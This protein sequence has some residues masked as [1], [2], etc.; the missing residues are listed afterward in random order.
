MVERFCE[1]R[2]H[3][4]EMRGWHPVPF[5]SVPSPGTMQAMLGSLWHASLGLALGETFN[6]GP[7]EKEP[8]PL[9]LAVEWQASR[10]PRL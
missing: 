3:V 2:M 4:L 10:V 8:S 9:Q 7:W 5:H 1:T 6:S